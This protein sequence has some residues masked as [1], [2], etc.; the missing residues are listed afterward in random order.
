LSSLELGGFGEV[1]K[2]VSR[3]SKNRIWRRLAVAFLLAVFCWLAAWLGAR[4]LIVSAPLEHADVIVVLSGSSSFVERTQLAAQLYAA[5]RSKRI[6]LTNDNQQS[7]WLSSEQRNPFFYERARWELQRHGVPETSI[8]VI[9]TPVNSTQEEALMLRNYAESNRLTSILVVTSAYHSR[10]A[11]LTFRR[12]MKDRVT[13]GLAAVPPG[14]QTPKPVTWW[15]YRRGWQ[16]VPGEYLKLM[17]Y[18]LRG[19]T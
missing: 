9:S 18:E 3:A 17:V 12:V 14:W 2:T 5:G 10:R 19:S 13:V 16:M 4:S 15:L 7:G 11:L 6:L 1:I 8:E